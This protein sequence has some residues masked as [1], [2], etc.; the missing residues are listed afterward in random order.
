[1]SAINTKSTLTDRYQ[2]TVPAPVR[3]AL[4]LTKRD[5]LIY[6]VL[7]NGQVLLSKEDAEED[8]VLTAFLQFLEQD[9]INH[10]DRVQPIPHNLVAE[11]DSLVGGMEVNLDAP[12]E[13]E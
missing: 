7:E 12:F 10:P 4:H 8:P 9:M 11:I 13:D 1:M 3:E 6:T 2:T 5:K